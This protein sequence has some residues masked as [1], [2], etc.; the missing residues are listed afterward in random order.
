MQS[1]LIVGNVVRQ[2]ELKEH[3]GTNDTSKINFTL[4]VKRNFSNTGKVDYVPFIAFNGVANN[5]SKYANYPGAK[6]AV[7]FEIQSYVYTDA[8]GKKHYGVQNKV[9]SVE[10]LTTKPKESNPNNPTDHV[11]NSVDQEQF[12]DAD[13]S[14]LNDIE[15][16]SVMN[17]SDYDI[18]GEIG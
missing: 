10:F 6:L 8:D 12:T 5:L 13:E 11:D 3:L 9:N 15:G 1:L 18:I 16:T 4:A 2:F 7:N 17:S 14:V